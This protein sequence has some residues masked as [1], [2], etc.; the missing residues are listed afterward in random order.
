M[1]DN[2]KNNNFDLLSKGS[3]VRLVIQITG[4]IM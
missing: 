3:V 4:S 2:V 1:F